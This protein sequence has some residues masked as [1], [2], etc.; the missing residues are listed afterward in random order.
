MIQHTFVTHSTTRDNEHGIAT[1]WLPGE[2]S[3]TGRGQALALGERYRGRVHELAEIYVSDLRRALE[4]VELA[5]PG[6][7]PPRFVDPR[8]RECNYGDLNGHPAREVHSQRLDRVSTPYPGGESFA[9]VVVRVAALLAGLR[10][11]GDRR[12][13]IVGHSATRYAL[14]HLVERRPLEDVIAAP[15]D[16]RPG[17]DYGLA[18]DS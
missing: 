10:S 3:A 1:G 15:G 11:G 12:V 4:T 18:A 7:T 17:W 8:L 9:D 14:E 2:L 6:S 5:F 16:W 13:L